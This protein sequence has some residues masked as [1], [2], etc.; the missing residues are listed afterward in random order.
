M[1]EADSVAEIDAI[2]DERAF[3]RGGARGEHNRLAL[4]RSDHLGFGLRAGLLLDE[5]EFAAFPVAPRLAEQEYH[6][7][8]ESHFTVEILVQAVVSA[9][10]VMKDEWRGFWFAR[11]CDKSLGTRHDREETAASFLRMLR[12]IR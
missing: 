2:V 1:N 8:R 6:L 11:P 10:F 4:I 9:N 7:Q 12:P 3:H 5:E